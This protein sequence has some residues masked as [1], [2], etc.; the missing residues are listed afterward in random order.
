LPDPISDPS[1]F[2][3]TLG[4]RVNQALQ[5]SQSS[6]AQQYQQMARAQ[7]LD[8]LWNR[9]STTQPELAKRQALVQGVAAIEFG[10]LRSQGLDPS[11]IAQQ[12][13][14]SLINMIAT[15]MQAELGTPTTPAPTGAARTADLSSG[16]VA[17]AGPPAS[18][19]AA[20]GFE[21]QL[22]AAQQKDGL[23]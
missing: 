18:P 11:A 15:R 3:E 20:P 4:Q 1:K 6:Q 5:T 12:N 14:D 16:S 10:N 13:P 9:F 19:P 22:K 8:S 7:A 17:P 21:A 23:F 2:R